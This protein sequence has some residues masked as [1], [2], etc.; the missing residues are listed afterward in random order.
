MSQMQENESYISQH[1]GMEICG[2]YLEF[3]Q[4]IIIKE[5]KCAMVVLK[6]EK[7]FVE[8]H[9]EVSRW[10]LSGLVWSNVLSNKGRLR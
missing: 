7:A 3:I 1:H 8:I 10:I 5:C 2:F 9:R 6:L 4:K